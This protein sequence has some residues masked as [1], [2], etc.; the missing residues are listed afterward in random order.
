[1]SDTLARLRTALAGRYTIEREVG[2]GGMA[3]V[4]EARDIR[5]HR[6]VAI[7][8]LRPELAEA[9]GAERFLRE[10]ETSANLR[11]PHILPLFDSGEADESLFFVMPFVEGESLRS[12]LDRQ[13]QLPIDEALLIALEV[14][15]ALHYAHSHGII[16]RDIKPENVLLES[17]HAVVA[18]FGIARALK[19]A[20]APGLTQTG[21]SLGT[22]RYMSPEQVA[23]DKDVDGRSDLY[24]LACVLYE[25][26]AGQPPFTGPTFERVVYQHLVEAPAPITR[27]R[28]TVPAAVAAALN[29]ALAKSPSER[30]STTAAFADA[31]RS[32]IAERANA[33]SVAVLPFANLSADP[34]N[35]YFAD[36]ITED[37]IAQISKIRSLKVVSRT[38][39]MPFKKREHDLRE[40][41]ARLQVGALLE[42]SV[43]RAGTRVRIV[44]QLIDV[45]TD[46]HLWAETYDR[47]L[48]DIFAIQSEV[49]LH[50]AG[51]LEARLSPDERARIRRRP[52]VDLQAYALYLHGRGHILRYTGDGFRQAI[53][54]FKRAIA[55]DPRYAA[56]YGGIAMAY[57]ELAET[58]EMPPDEAY[59]LA[60]EAAAQAIAIDGDLADAHSMVAYV[61]MTYE[62][63]WAG[64]ESEFKRAL[65]LNPNSAEAYD[66][67]GRLLQSLERYDDAIAMQERAHELDPIVNKTDVA[68]A[69]LRAGRHAEAAE[70]AMR[71]VEVDREDP[72]THFTLGWA[73]LGLGKQREGLAEME[74][75]VE[76]AAGNNIWLAQLGEA[77]AL[78]G[79]RDK[80]E[81]ILER[82]LERSRTSYVSPYHFAYV[83]TGLGRHDE[84]MDYLERASEQRAGSIYGIKG[85][86]LFAPLRSH[87]RF[88]ALLRKMNLV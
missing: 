65:E 85:S 33:R 53:E 77:Y 4:Y 13:R 22:P 83:Y 79:M 30:F 1:V 14:A 27:F 59:P 35:E 6:K 48:T 62:F 37:V 61:K 47:E 43:R 24:G 52:T 76:L 70:L 42:G 74:H 84:A 2:A 57:T 66:L 36:G 7:K 11:H 71:A 49:A 38:S 63:D 21:S 40:I 50:I 56:A 25:M 88:V 86:F 54:F 80:A 82:L 39:V 9:L 58:G 29:R 23:G 64:A 72:R 3:R 10:I 68:T 28:P 69:Y 60:K 51:A 18:D 32:P 78:N 73:Y 17:G 41:A 16:H 31:L 44:A 46:E 20:D 8:V 67:Y 19:T 15:D 55:R 87:P 5:H 26:L 12:R 81:A 45:A 34:E 75:A